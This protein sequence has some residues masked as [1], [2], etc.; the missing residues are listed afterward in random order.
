MRL[1]IS[2]DDLSPHP[3]IGFGALNCL[4]EIVNGY[5]IK[6]SLF[7]PTS[8]QRFGA[9][10]KKHYMLEDF[11][12]FVDRIKALPEKYFEVCYHGHKHGQKRKKSNNDEFRYLRY[13]EAIDILSRSKE[14]FDNVGIKVRPV[15]RPPGFWI[16]KAAI[17]A[18]AEF[19]IKVLA[20]HDAKRYMRSYGKAAK[21]YK[22]TVLPGAQPTKGDSIEI[23]YHAGSDQPDY[24][25][26]K[27]GIRLRKI[28][29]RQRWSYI[30]MEEFFGKRD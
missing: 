20:L 5:N 10:E 11:P 17:K 13:D 6:V 19:G 8:V 15:L 25:N 7:I 27:Q 21:R 29:K 12:E 9:R 30:F 18:C 16:S 26:K 3:N 22:H 1:N 4:Q 14:I 23:F 2:I 28:I 24:F